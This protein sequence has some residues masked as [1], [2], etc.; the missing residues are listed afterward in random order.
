MTVL[1]HN[2]LFGHNNHIC[3][4]IIGKRWT[5]L[6]SIYAVKKYK[7]IYFLQIWDDFI[8]NIS[9]L[10]HILWCL[11]PSKYMIY[12]LMKSKVTGIY[13]KRVMQSSSKKKEHD[14]DQAPHDRAVPAWRSGKAMCEAVKEKPG[15]CW[16]LQD[17][18]GAGDMGY[19]PRRD[20]NRERNHP[21]RKVC[22]RHQ[23]RKDR[24]IS[25]LYTRNKT[26]GF[27]VCSSGF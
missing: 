24:A 6:V 23:R 5:L 20:A 4:R 14:W 11:H 10:Y 3:E 8:V 16:K 2:R 21:K 13:H 1:I 7:N 15:L 25:A 22:C 9:I 17:V 26:T 12:I 18:R 19:L 27:G